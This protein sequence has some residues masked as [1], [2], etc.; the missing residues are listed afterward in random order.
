MVKAFQKIFNFQKGLALYVCLSEKEMRQKSSSS[1]RFLQN[2]SNITHNVLKSNSTQ[3]SNGQ[4][5]LNHIQNNL[6]L[7]LHFNN[8]VIVSTMC[9]SE[10]VIAC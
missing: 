4:H 1:Q 9:H 8:I 7:V 6:G 10:S 5:C 3:K 2:I